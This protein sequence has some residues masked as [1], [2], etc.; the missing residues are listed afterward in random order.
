MSGTESTNSTD[1]PADTHRISDLGCVSVNLHQQYLPPLLIF[2]VSIGICLIAYII[3]KF[4]RKWSYLINFIFSIWKLNFS[5][6]LAYYIYVWKSNQLDELYNFTSLV[7]FSAHILLSIM[8]G[9][10]IFRTMLD[11]VLHSKYIASNGHCAP[12]TPVDISMD[13]D[14]RFIHR[15]MCFRNF[16][17]VLS[18]FASCGVFRSMYSSAT[19]QKGAIWFL[20]TDQFKE[21]RS[22]MDCGQY[23]YTLIVEIP[24]MVMNIFFLATFDTGL[25]NKY[26]VEAILFCVFDVVLFALAQWELRR[27]RPLNVVA[28]AASKS[29]VA[30]ESIKAK[31]EPRDSFLLDQSLDKDQHNLVRVTSIVS[32]LNNP[33]SRPTPNH[34]VDLKKQR[35]M[36]GK[37]TPFFNVSNS[38]G[39]K[40]SNAKPI[41]EE[42]GEFNQP[43]SPPQNKNHSVNI[44]GSA[45]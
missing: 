18:L 39:K 3:C 21:V 4:W 13:H 37:S 16:I 9:L 34:K 17:F 20:L 24:F 45:R 19:K 14:P 1:C 6:F 7:I 33:S 44:P 10:A 15:F 11:P 29:Q 12:V 26:M 40:T 38:P 43:Q 27:K 22:V 42:S 2:C 32:P 8:L 41:R 36:K 30:V 35:S 25:N 5:I 23:S 28:N 31:E